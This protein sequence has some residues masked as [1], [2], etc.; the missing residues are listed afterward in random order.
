MGSTRLIATILLGLGAGV[1]FG[2]TDHDTPT[3]PARP[4]YNFVNGPGNAGPYVVRVQ[5]PFPPGFGY[6]LIGID[7]ARNRLSVIGLGS[8]D[9]AQSS[10]CKPDGAFSIL[11]IQEVFTPSGA[12]KF[13]ADGQTV[14]QHVYAL[15]AGGG[16]LD[17][18]NNTGLCDALKLPRLAQGTGVFHY[19]ESNL[20]LS[21]KAPDS[22]GWR[23]QGTLDDLVNGGQIRYQEEA[24]LIFDQKSGSF[25]LFLD[26]ILL[27][28][29]GGP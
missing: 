3:A 22:F 23:A 5:G 18:W 4:A 17:V 13:L 29:V 27:S 7:I 11:D 14:T 20:S 16:W 10:G 21:G 26:R 28:P 8:L 24:R 25:R 2:C 12:V 19:T 1:Q 9:P 15:D 6:F